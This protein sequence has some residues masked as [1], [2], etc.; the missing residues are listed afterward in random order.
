MIIHRNQMLR[1]YILTCFKILHICAHKV[2]TLLLIYLSIK[3]LQKPCVI[4]KLPF[5]LLNINENSYKTVM[6]DEFSPAH[7]APKLRLTIL[8]GTKINSKKIFP[9]KLPSSIIRITTGRKLFRQIFYENCKA[10]CKL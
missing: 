5:T 1:V 2:I 3:K 8:Y 7:S 9:S 4:V 10:A 6:W